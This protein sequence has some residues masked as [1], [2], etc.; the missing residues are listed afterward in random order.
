MK[1]LIILALSA[2]MAIGL[3]GCKKD[4]D[5]NSEVT[6]LSV[7][8]TAN[9]KNI[10]N[11]TADMRLWYQINPALF[12]DK[13]T[14]EPGTLRSVMTDIE[15]LSDGDAN[16]NTDL[17]MSGIL[18]TDLL[19]LDDNMVTRDLQTMNPALGTENDLKS[20]CSRAASLNMPVMITLEL[21]GISTENSDFR[22][23]VDLVNS[24]PDVEFEELVNRDPELFGMFYVDKD[25]SEENYTRIGNTSFFY[26]SLPQS[27]TPRLNL[28][29]TIVR[30]MIE[31]LVTHYTDLGVSGF[32][33]PDYTDLYV[34][35]DENAA[36]FM[37]WFDA[38]VK[39]KNPKAINVFTYSNWA[40]P[41]AN[42][43]A[44]AADR[45]SEGAEGMLAKAATGTINA[46]ELGTYLEQNSQRT[47]GATASFINST[48]SSLDLLKSDA[49]LA[50]YKMTLALQLM[51]SGQIFITSGDELGLTSEQAELI[52]DAIENP[53]EE[54]NAQDSSEEESQTQI[55]LQFGSLFEQ[56]ADGNSI[57]N[58]VQQ[59]ILLRDSYQSIQSGSITM[60]GDLSNER[61]LVL[62]KTTSNSQTVLVF[63]LSGDEQKVNTESIQISGLP[64]ELGGMLLTSSK[65]ITLED[66][67]L[68]LPPYSM[69][70]LK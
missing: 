20:L 56:K 17:N 49:R 6:A 24:N 62:N 9:S 19:S 40:D 11:G 57:L 55:D 12:T 5:K 65:E 1:K 22:R 48:N 15:Y 14:G 43:P 27:D 63:N 34:N 7:M 33:I 32:Y 2:A 58:F 47:Q 69:A 35:K 10:V 68:T 61:V 38:M 39:E 54:N 70:L 66:N 42:I 13:A 4:N 23:L 51:T 53:D 36:E 16:T 8:Q 67:T 37:T 31:Q 41:I 30:Q 52:V 3:A 26:Q 50:Q 21:A 44:F 64:A 28:D 46:T 25:K 29:S 59:A 60:N 18:L 45:A